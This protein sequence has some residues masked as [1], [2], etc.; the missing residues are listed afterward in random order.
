MTH[1][2]T[3]GGPR[4]LLIG[5]RTNWGGSLISMLEASR[6]TVRFARDLEEITESIKPTSFDLILAGSEC[7]HEM[8]MSPELAGSRT[9]VYYV[10]PVENSCWWVPAMLGGVD[11]YGSS[12]L[13]PAEF[14]AELREILHR[15]E[16]Q[17]MKVA[18]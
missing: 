2:G 11:C 15:H 8:H 3:N 5:Q 18:S 4:V 7:R 12:A 10:F 14:A 6:C 17:T 9:S 13:R 1:N 16:G